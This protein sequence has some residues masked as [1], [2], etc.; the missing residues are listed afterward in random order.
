MENCT[1][2]HVCNSPVDLHTVANLHLEINQYEGS[3]VIGQVVC[4]WLFVPWPEIAARADHM[5]YVVNTVTLGQVY[6][7][8]EL[9][10]FS[11][12]YFHPTSA[13][14]SV[15]CCR[16]TDN[17]PI[18]VLYQ[19]P[20]CHPIS[21][22]QNDVQYWCHW[23]VTIIG[24][25]KTLPYVTM[26]ADSLLD[27]LFPAPRPTWCVQY[28]NHASYHPRTHARMHARTHTHNDMNS[29]VKYIANTRSRVRYAANTSHRISQWDELTRDVCSSHKPPDCTGEISFTRCTMFWHLFTLLLRNGSK[30]HFLHLQS[31]KVH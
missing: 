31:S 27:Y 15:F 17:R 2:W 21:R 6:L 19:Q 30:S 4:R 9:F 5:G 20:Q 12:L 18:K 7:S 16:R 11:P 14:H 25:L 23:A 1:T 28:L 8:E 13:A 3:R 22:T 24:P 26:P 10:R 29:C